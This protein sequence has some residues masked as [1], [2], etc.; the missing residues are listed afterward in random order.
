M[1]NTLAFLLLLFAASFAACIKTEFDEPPAGG[2][3]VDDISNTTIADLK[4]RHVT[5]GGFDVIQEDLIIGGVVTMDD[6]SGNYFKTLVIQDAT[7]GI[8]VKFNDASLYNQFPI[9]RKIYIKC[10][11]LILTDF[12]TITQITGSLFNE[13]G[14]VSAIG[15]TQAQ[16]RRNIVKGAIGPPPAPAKISIGDL[17]PS[18][19]S[20]LVELQDVQ[21]ITADTGRTYADPVTK[22][23][24]NRRLEDCNSLQTIV[25]TSGYADFAGTKTP[26]GRGTVTGIVGIFAGAYQL[27]IRNTGD[28]RL[29]NPR[30]AG[31]QL[32]EMTIGGVRALFGGS[33]TS[34]PSN[35]FV[36]GVVISDRA[37]RNVNSRNL[38][39]QDATAGIA[40]RFT[41]DHTFDLGDELEIDISGQEL[42]EFMQ[43]LQLNNI[44]L[45]NAKV[46]SKNKTAAPRMATVSEINANHSAWESTLVRISNAS[47]TGGSTFGGNRTLSDGTGN[48]TLFTSNS[49]TFAGSPIPSGP[50]TVTA[51][52]SDFNGKQL[53]LRNLSDIE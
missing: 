2:V 14:G 47:I 52:V 35:R 11:G 34:V 19:L 26:G 15:L 7:G 24:V 20:M 18:M 23:S 40:V 48:I 29:D 30:C 38:F 45:S 8:E 31:P 36:R 53:L 21:F 12:N 1:K 10:Q 32:T 43:L 9:G 37:A 13:G 5:L 4:T 42:S 25:R 33:T 3:E 50:K 51:I 16:V 6:R 17:N 39:L 28:V 49:S 41:G 27:Y 46:L 44:N 22:N